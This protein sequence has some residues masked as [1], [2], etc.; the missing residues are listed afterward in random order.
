MFERRN[1]KG[2]DNKIWKRETQNTKQKDNEE[3]KMKQY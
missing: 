1:K 2:T 3:R